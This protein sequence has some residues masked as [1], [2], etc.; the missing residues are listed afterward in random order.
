MMKQVYLFL[1]AMML[2]CLAPMPYGY[3]MLVRFVA[4]V[5]FGI[6]AYRYYVNNKTAAAWVFGVL[7][8]LFQPFY[9]ITLG[10]GLWNV[11][12]V[13]VAVLLVGLFVLEK[14]LGKKDAGSSRQLPPQ[15]QIKLEG[16]VFEFSLNGKLSP[17]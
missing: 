13:V 6:M 10:R 17:K 3:Y 1:A 11:V 2:L 8:L 9:K 14:R 15:D 16:N 7:A 12:D 5:V 4:M